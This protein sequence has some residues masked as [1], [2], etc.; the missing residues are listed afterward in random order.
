MHSDIRKAYCG[1]SHTRDMKRI[2]VPNEIRYVGRA[3][4]R[5][6]FCIQNVE[7]ETASEVVSMLRNLVQNMHS[8]L[9]RRRYLY[10]EPGTLCFRCCLNAP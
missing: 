5:F 2:A 9:A 8:A 4:R 10:S 6:R 3:V 1:R 7:K